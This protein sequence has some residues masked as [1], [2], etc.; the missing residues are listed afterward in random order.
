MKAKRWLAALLAA[1]MV[2]GSVT[3]VSA[4]ETLSGNSWWG[5]GDGGYYGVGKNVAVTGSGS[6]YYT[7]KVDELVEG[8][9]VF[10]V[11]MFDNADDEGN[12][13]D[14]SR[15]LTTTSD[16]DA[17]TANDPA[18]DFG[19][20]SDGS[21][22][23][24]DGGYCVVEI[25]RDGQNFTVEYFIREDS[26]S[27]DTI[28][29]KVYT[30]T[31]TDTDFGETVYWRVMAQIGTFTFSDLS[32]GYLVTGVENITVNDLTAC[33]LPVS[34]T[35][36]DLD[37][38]IG[39]DGLLTISGEGNYV[40]TGTYYDEEAE[41]DVYYE[42]TYGDWRDYSRWI[43]SAYVDVTGITSMAE[44]FSGCYNLTSVEFS[45]NTDTSN[46]TSMC[47]MFQDCN[48]L[49][50]ITWNNFSTGSVENMNG[51]F[52]CC[53]SIE[54]L[55]LSFFETSNVTAMGQMFC[56]CYNLTSL[57]VSSFDTSNVTD[58]YQMFCNVDTESEGVISVDVSNFDTSKV[59]NM[60]DMFAYSGFESLDL[61]SFDTS[62]VTNMAYMFNDSGNLTSIT[63]P[64]GF[65]AG[66]EDNYEPEEG[67]EG[68]TTVGLPYTENYYWTN[69]SG[70]T[71]TEIALG[72]ENAV[73]Y[74]RYRETIE[75]TSGDLSWYID[76]DGVLTIEGTGD[77]AQGETDAEYSATPNWWNYREYITS[78][79]VSVSGIT[80][81]ECMFFECYNMTSVDLSG[82][83]TSS[84]TTMRSMFDCCS[85]LSEIKGLSGLDMS[86]VTDA[87]IMFWGCSSLTS[88]DVN[89]WDT[90][91]LTDVS[92]MFE[93][94]SG[95][96]SLD[97]TGWTNT[98]S[99]TDTG[100]MISGC[101]S[102]TE[103]KVPA[104]FVPEAWWGIEL[105]YVY[106]CSWTNSSGD[107][108]D[109]ITTG[110]DSEETYTR[111]GEP[112]TTYSGWSWWEDYTPVESGTISG[113]GTWAYVID[114]VDTYGEC[115]YVVELSDVD[116]NLYITTTGAG[117]AWTANNYGD[118]DTT[119]SGVEI[120]TSGITGFNYE[121]GGKYV[122]EIVKTSSDITF[123]Y[124][125]ISGSDALL[126]LSYEVTGADAFGDEL[127]VRFMAQVGCF[128]MDFQEGSY[129]GEMEVTDIR[130]A[131][132]S[133]GSWNY[134]GSNEMS[135]D[136]TW[137]YVIET[138]YAFGY[139]IFRIE[140]IDSE[141][142]WNGISTMIGSYFE[143]Y[144]MNE[145][146]GE[147]DASRTTDISFEL[148]KD[149]TY[150]AEIT[151][152]GSTLTV[153]Y[154]QLVDDSSAK[155][156]YAVTYTDDSM[157]DTL[158]SIP[159]VQRGAYNVTF[160]DGAYVTA[161]DSSYSSNIEDSTKLTD[162]V[163]GQAGSL[164]WNLTTEGTLTISGTGD[165]ATFDSDGNVEDNYASWRDYA[166]WIT[167]VVV[168]DVSGITYTS[169][170]FAGL[171][172]ATEI[173]LSGL[174]TAGVT[175]M[176]DMFTECSS[177]TSIDVSGFD[178]SSVTVMSWM[179]FDCGSL[180][181]I[182]GLSNFETSSVDE[183]IGMFYG[184]GSLTSIDVSSFDTSNVVYMYMMFQG[185][186]SL[187]SIDVSSFDTSN[188]V[189]MQMMF[190]GCGALE[191]I[192]F[193]ENF[194]TGN[195]TD[196]YC[197]FS[198]CSSLASIDVSTF[199]TSN[200]TD[201]CGMF[202]R[203]SSLT[204]LDVSGFDTS[205][206][207]NMSC[208]F[209]D[210]SALESLV[211]SG[212][213]TSSVENMSCMFNGCGALTSITFGSGFDTS[214]VYDMSHMFNGCGALTSLDVSGFN[215]SN[216]Y[217]MSHMFQG[218]GNLKSLDVSG[219][220]TSGVEYMGDMFT[221]CLSLT[222]LDVSNWDTS[223]VQH[224]DYMFSACE[225]L[226]SLDLSS[227]NTSNVDMMYCMFEGC[228]SLTSVDVSGWNTSNV[229]SMSSMFKNC[230]ALTELDVHEFDTTSL[231]WAEDF[232]SGC[233][234]LELLK[235]PA[236]FRTYDVT[237]D[238]S[239]E[240]VYT[241]QSVELPTV[242]GYYWANANA[243]TATSIAPELDSDMWY[244][245]YAD[246]EEAQV[247]EITYPTDI[248]TAETTLT[249]EAESYSYT[250][251]AIEPSV[252]VVC[253]GT[254]LTKDTDYTVSYSD[255]T[256]A[257]TATVTIEGIDNYTGTLETS[258][259]ITKAAQTVTASISASSI[260]V[261]NTATITASTNGDGALTYS[262]SDT[263][264][265]TVSSSGVVSGVSKGSAT[266][267]VTAAG[268]DNYEE[269]TA[270]ISVA[271]GAINISGAT[272]TL[273]TTS[274]TYDGTAKTPTVSSVV[275]NEVK[276]TSGTDYTVSYSNNTNAGTATVTITGTGNYAGT[277][278]AKFTINKAA[279]TVTVSATS[280]SISVGGTSTV[281]GKTSGNGSITYASSNTSVATVSSSGVVTAVAK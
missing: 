242:D 87:A 79:V 230:S 183:M 144:T 40:Q 145:A 133:N 82:M 167:K 128:A 32:E 124:Y 116:N 231:T 236:A 78:A 202:Q 137:S 84:V 251:S 136:S 29:D 28:Y 166:D 190:S 266:I 112:I 271:V 165:Y 43:T 239:G 213:N 53:T 91:N 111:T 159:I 193:G 278:T 67:Q 164:E 247:V 52:L 1:T 151:K 45:E 171:Y 75:G 175:N 180:T 227:F 102:L 46:V 181:E 21:G 34:G 42:D 90:P 76:S 71:V 117:D 250:G 169:G 54:S 15:Y 55:D 211:L 234:S 277:A 196:M 131:L 187:T 50:D 243:E 27:E 186:G 44:M 153:N 176:G 20:A 280:T 241:L 65:G 223:N 256:N 85:S 49:R 161:E 226:E 173:D 100:S 152:S 3:G 143:A 195:V 140:I 272:V 232:V 5:E 61:S 199:N 16:R 14:S 83:D 255:N 64:A 148:Q 26:E 205:R 135:G 139:D 96:T 70:E 31:M 248:T 132:V 182:T 154:Y 10:V 103:V 98:S 69:D 127:N 2:L 56:N 221:G 260:T 92:Q 225:S 235:V 246:G 244:I 184:C 36:G 238:E 197:M 63:I 208:M 210:C 113:V 203:C 62:S 66:Y 123:N 59:T 115:G 134:G 218:C 80:S 94:C 204:S 267:T 233:T 105:P 259:T 147:L 19:T 174:N 249:L 109:Y 252:T 172:K 264:V 33:P 156:V 263:S 114:V 93:G 188:V 215:T 220:N 39:E 214:N 47:Y 110:N 48:S 162:T 170:M 198:D 229:Q 101:T 177:L 86:N 104:N 138:V 121:D 222:S 265:A 77:Y 37:W 194:T 9:G 155:L 212:F 158:Y 108:C 17:W 240:W 216:V 189:Y 237:E 163:Y 262:S 224:M 269:G 258:F 4:E 191:S 275:C 206:V 273:G 146:C 120:N 270:K 72:A 150:V 107:G 168:N 74:T 157:A 68:E 11:E 24:P 185:C 38:S 57:N 106:G 276:L 129:V 8:Y 141:D 12:T 219:F 6:W 58:M 149:V 209:E 95:L 253:D 217:E 201:M 122:V 23:L 279:Q 7:V 88:I 89:G 130:D 281:S 192:T 142:S 228:S 81:T 30:V 160:Y 126:F 274:Y 13:T 179:F 73:T 245:R 200:V 99:I 60:H 25:T 125:M 254:T 268:T 18:G 261:G 97:F 51:M 22:G 257:G 118:D 207:E 119:L 41:E 35:D 178:T